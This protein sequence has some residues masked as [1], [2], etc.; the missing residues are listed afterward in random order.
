MA[1]ELQNLSKINCVFCLVMMGTLCLIAIPCAFS[2]PRSDEESLPL[3]SGAQPMNAQITVSRTFQ[4]PT[5]FPIPL[6]HQYV[7]YD[8]T[9]KNTGSILIENQR[10]WTHFISEGKRT[11]D[12]A[13]FAIPPLEPGEN[14]TIHLGPL[15][16]LQGGMHYLFMGINSAGRMDIPDGLTVNYS[17]I[18]YAD[19]FM[20]F[21]TLQLNFA[22]LGIA[23]VVT[24]AGIL[25]GLLI[26]RSKKAGETG[27][28]KGSNQ[29]SDNK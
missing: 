29:Q 23:A 10:L 24:G 9:I 14:T 3:L 1:E 7:S 28:R 18:H 15:K 2:L 11:N 27:Y 5:L 19:S 20:V 4:S 13:V 16:M 21:D 22:T 6:A 17:P 25:G 8:I 12:T 26:Y